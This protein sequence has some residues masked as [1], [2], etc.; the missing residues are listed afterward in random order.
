MGGFQ[1]FNDRDAMAWMRSGVPEAL[2][3]PRHA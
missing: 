3:Q 2:L 1:P